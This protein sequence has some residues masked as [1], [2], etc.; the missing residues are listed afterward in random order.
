MSRETLLGV[1][2]ATRSAS[3]RTTTSH[4]VY[5]RRLCAWVQWSRACQANAC[6]WTSLLEL[7]MGSSARLT[8]SKKE[9]ADGKLPLRLHWIFWGCFR[10]L[11]S[12][13]GAALKV[14][15]LIHL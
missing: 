10:S 8:V 12:D 15:L 7:M 3:D 4:R 11:Q 2:R 1:R 6:T 9:R 13:A 5:R 14:L